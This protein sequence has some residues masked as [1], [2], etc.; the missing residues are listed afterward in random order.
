MVLYEYLGTVL[1]C[2]STI[3]YLRTGVWKN[4]KTTKKKKRKRKRKMKTSLC[5]GVVEALCDAHQALITGLKEDALDAKAEAWH[6]A[7]TVNCLVAHSAC[8]EAR[9]RDKARRTR[10]R[11]VRVAPALKNGTTL[12][13]FGKVA[14][15]RESYGAHVNRDTRTAAVAGAPSKSDNGTE[16]MNSEE[17]E[18][19]EEEEESWVQL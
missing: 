17:E 7:R 15:I 1:Y 19:E 5:H 8:Q 9:A 4:K 13:F 14:S 10:W 18:E 11:A 6:L 12:G 3:Q 16:G 2:T